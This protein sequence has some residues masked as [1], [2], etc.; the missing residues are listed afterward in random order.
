MVK[1][2]IKIE[3]IKEQIEIIRVFLD[4]FSMFQELIKFKDE[5]PKEKYSL[6]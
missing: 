3:T 4:I 6:L 1:K 5:E 2:K